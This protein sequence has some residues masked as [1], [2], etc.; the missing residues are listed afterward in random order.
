MS[1][2]VTI[3]GGAFS[4]GIDVTVNGDTSYEGDEFF[5]VMTVQRGTP[6][7]ARYSFKHA[8]VQDTAYASLLKS[9]RQHLHALAAQVLETQFSKIATTEPELLAHHYTSADLHAQAINYWYQA[10][11]QANQRSAYT[12]AISNL[13][14]GL[15]LLDELP[16]SRERTQSAE[17]MGR[18]RAPACG[19][20]ASS[21]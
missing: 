2:T 6:P 3:P 12:E 21:D 7:E 18:C 11:A 4:A 20:C 9:K 19:S 5:V 1:G 14:K 10:G 13:N 15:H 16:A 17:A 8:L